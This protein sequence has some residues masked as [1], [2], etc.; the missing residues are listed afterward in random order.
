MEKKKVLIKNTVWKYEMRLKWNNSHC[1][2]WNM[3][4]KWIVCCMI[5]DEWVMSS[6][7]NICIHMLKSAKCLHLVSQ[8]H[9]IL[10]NQLCGGVC[11]QVHSSSILCGD[12]W[13][14]EALR[15][16]LI[17]YNCQNA[18]DGVCGRKEINK[19]NIR[20]LETTVTLLFF[21]CSSKSIQFICNFL[22]KY[23]INLSLHNILNSSIH[24][25]HTN[26]VLVKRREWVRCGK[27]V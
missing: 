22:L 16:K 5:A 11:G 19:K 2:Q 14:G 15:N 13:C 20:R 1:L 18:E 3:W 24:I 9:S 27:K 6:R 26:L 12:P 7:I 10:Q 8:L 25:F 17:H 23:F 21:N 4:M